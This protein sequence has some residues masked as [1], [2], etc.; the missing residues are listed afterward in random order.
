MRT[1]TSEIQFAKPRVY[2]D[3]RTAA[4]QT[5]EEVAAMRLEQSAELIQG[6]VLVEIARERS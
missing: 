3:R 1:L 5:H 4:A 6:F 2:L